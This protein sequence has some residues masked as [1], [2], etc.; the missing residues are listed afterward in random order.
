MKLLKIN[1]FILFCFLTISNLLAQK[2][3]MTRKEHLDAL[4]THYYLLNDHLW[5]YISHIN[6]RDNIN[7]LDKKRRATAKLF[8]DEQKAIKEIGTYKNDALIFEALNI[9]IEENDAILKNELKNLAD[10]E[11]ESEESIE[12]MEKLLK[13]IQKINRQLN[14]ITI[15]YINVVKGY[16]SKYFSKTEYT[17]H[18][19]ARHEN[20]NNRLADVVKIY[21][22]F[23]PIYLDFL[24]SKEL[25]E[26]YYHEFAQKNSENV[27]ELGKQLLE[28]N[29]DCKYRLKNLN[30]Y[31]KDT[32]LVSEFNTVL[33]FREK[34][35]S[36]SIPSMM[37]YHQK[38]IDFDKARKEFMARDKSTLKPDDYD[39]MDVLVA[40]INTSNSEYNTLYNDFFDDRNELIFHFEKMAK[41]FLAKHI[42]RE[43]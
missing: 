4:N 23:I 27:N 18:K 40:E 25:E 26:K 13:E 14:E 36:E 17:I 1:I 37:K 12:N 19:E 43:H 39:Q 2:K 8:Y 33:T 41:V 5:K 16:N 11:K 22:H 20:M 15:K 9:Y 35:V 28:L 24:K 38:Q 31:N 29:E 21:D 34:E 30:L 6:N 3:E 32:S 7:K 42:I 10:L